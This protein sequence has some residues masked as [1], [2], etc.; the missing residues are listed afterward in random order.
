MIDVKDLIRELT[1][2]QLLAAADGYFAS[3]KLESEQCWKPFSN[4]LD[5]T[6][7]TRHLGWVLSASNL[8]RGAKVVDFG[9][10]TGWLTHALAQMGCHATGID[11]SINALH[12]A[13]QLGSKVDSVKPSSYGSIDFSAYDGNRLPLE[14][15]SVDRII[16]FDAFHHVR[17]QE[18]TLKEFSRVLK[19]G[20]RA[21][22]LEPGPSHS[23][24]AQSQAEMAAHAVIENDI[25]MG[26]IR[27]YS[28]A[29]GFDKPVMLLQYMNPVMIGVDDYLSWSEGRP[30]ADLAKKLLSPLQSHLTNVQCFFLQKGSQVRNSLQRDGLKAQFELKYWSLKDGLI[31]FHVCVINTGDRR[32]LSSPGSGQ[33]NMGLQI[34]DTY[35]RMLNNDYGRVR[36]SQGD[37]DPGQQVHLSGVCAAPSETN[38][39]VQLDMVSEMVCWFADVG[40]T[41]PLKLVQPPH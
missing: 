36:L 17:D 28:Q 40:H 22:F 16:C 2:E 34:V 5:A 11:I 24:S 31:H 12:L 23:K 26:S 10:G 15:E 21:A 33:V 39:L 7:L 29:A 8:F 20:G 9:C 4:P 6:Y 35:G 14:N 27:G 25:E 18:Q 37:V 32:W 30:P 19:Q 41:E 38:H 1:Q 13:R 3:M